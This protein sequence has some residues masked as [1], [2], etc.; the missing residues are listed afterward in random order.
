MNLL[1]D[2]LA[3]TARQIGALKAK[4]TSQDAVVDGINTRVGT[5]ESNITS[6]TT[7]VN[8]MAT[9]DSNSAVTLYNNPTG[10]FDGT[11][12][13]SQPIT[14]FDFLDIFYI[15]IGSGSSRGGHSTRIPAV[16]GTYELR[17]WDADPPSSDFS[18]SIEYGEQIVTISGSTF[19]ASSNKEIS[20][21]IASQSSVVVNTGSYRYNITK[22]VGIKMGDASPAE[23]QD[24]R[25]GVDNVTYPSA[26]D[27]IRT[28]FLSS[29]M[30]K[31]A[32]SLGGVDLNTLHSVG[33][34]WHGSLDGAVT[35]LPTELASDAVFL[36][37]VFEANDT[38]STYRNC[39]VLITYG[40]DT[41]MFYRANR[42]TNVY[43]E[44][45]KIPQ[46]DD[47]LQLDNHISNV[48]DALSGIA[49]IQN[50][51]DKAHAVTGGYFSDTGG[52][53]TNANSF[54]GTEYIPVSEGTYYFYKEASKQ[55]LYCTYD[56]NK[57]F[58]A[59]VDPGYATSTIG[60][61]TIGSGVAFIRPCIYGSTNIDVLTISTTPVGDSLPHTYG[62][63]GQ[64]VG[65]DNL[66]DSART[67]H[68][69]YNQ[70]PL[71][72]SA[73]TNQ[74]GYYG[75]YGDF[76]ANA[77]YQSIYYQVGSD[78][79]CYFDSNATYYSI[80]VFSALPLSRDTCV[81]H[82]LRHSG[83]EDTAP[84]VDSK[85]SLKEGQYV[86]ITVLS[87]DTGSGFYTNDILFGVT[88]NDNVLLSS[89]QLDQISGTSGAECVAVPYG[90][91][92]NAGVYVFVPTGYGYLRYD[93][94]HSYNA[95]INCDTWRINSLYSVDDGFNE[96]F[97]ATTS[98]EWECAVRLD[99]RPDFSGG[100]MHG[101]EV[102]TSIVF[103]FDGVPYDA[104]TLATMGRKRFKEMRIIEIST[105]YDPNDNVTEIA[106]HYKEYIFDN[107][108]LHLLQ[109]VDW[110]ITDT[111]SSCF[112]AMLTPSKLY[113]DMYYS[114]KELEPVTSLSA[115]GNH[116]GVK[117]AV[118][119]S[120]DEGFLC[121]LE[122]LQYP[123]GLPG[124]DIF[125]L[126]DN[127]GGDY[128]KMYFNVC[129]S[130]NITAGTRWISESVYS[131]YV[132]EPK[133]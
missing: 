27:A 94:K 84:K 40:A 5:A 9:T 3:F 35:N 11:I 6:L 126:R 91:G 133:E 53:T 88:L 68:I 103:F 110:K 73:V 131:F 71:S 23:L 25:V 4:N 57:N 12:N 30:K 114:D 36:L 51:F 42:D 70:V 113:T 81:Q 107:K 1:S 120:S 56:S 98:G 31:P 130:G 44:W 122:I 116:A 16:A 34:Y 89:S 95:S 47:L 83:S 19:T 46:T 45:E 65:F 49:K 20:F 79:D 24:I 123:T 22:I 7:R 117:R 118:Q 111:L 14:N 52:I 58:I 121:S 2:L 8:T 74:S 102:T 78:C 61:F 33:I 54:Y 90:S 63:S 50:L 66:K 29:L 108:D 127:N 85:L 80:C 125:N 28:Q 59:R 32:T 72:H 55:L 60:S 105:L 92:N 109:H 67:V 37:I 106:D 77:N 99:G 38:N 132:G 86:A 69:S 128:N 96:R 119:Y 76:T 21:S 87:S 10:F 62:L 26:G 39:Q 17:T 97:L 82:R 104:A 13:L 41:K 15:N 100:V 124:S 101:D 129:T 93:F 48:E 43:G 75:D 112:L 115:Y 18:A 64:V